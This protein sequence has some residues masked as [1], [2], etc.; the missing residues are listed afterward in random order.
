MHPGESLLRYDPFSDYWKS[1]PYVEQR[2]IR[3]IFVTNEEEI[4]VLSVSLQLQG[5]FTKLG[6]L[7]RNDECHDHRSFSKNSDSSEKY[8]YY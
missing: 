3:K 1:I 2:A 8:S 5:T 7:N 6:W 4:S